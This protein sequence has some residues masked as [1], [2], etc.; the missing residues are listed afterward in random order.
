MNKLNP[1]RTSGALA[2]TAFLIGALFAW[3]YNLAGKSSCSRQ[4]CACVGATCRHIRC[5]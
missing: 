5:S 2:L 4:R 1:W 3:C